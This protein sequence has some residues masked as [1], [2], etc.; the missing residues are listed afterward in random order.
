MKDGSEILTLMLKVEGE[1]LT[2]LCQTATTKPN[3]HARVLYSLSSETLTHLE[4]D[5][6]GVKKYRT[7]VHS[8]IGVLSCTCLCVFVST[9]A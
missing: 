3:P 1:L 9:N 4:R 5:G 2:A 7:C 8:R 6:E